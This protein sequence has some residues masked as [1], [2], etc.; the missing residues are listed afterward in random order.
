MSESSYESA[1]SFVMAKLVA[2]TATLERPITHKKLPKI[3]SLGY[4]STPVFKSLKRMPN[5][6]YETELDSHT[7]DLMMQKFRKKDFFE[8]FKDTMLSVYQKLTK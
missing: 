7:V 8:T 2:R 4:G 1:Q 3:F 6:L 5:G